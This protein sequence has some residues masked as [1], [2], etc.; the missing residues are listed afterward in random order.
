M[1]P[2]RLTAF[3][4]CTSD[5]KPQ[6]QEAQRIAGKLYLRVSFPNLQKAKDKDTSQ[7]AAREERP[8]RRKDDIWPLLRN[9]ASKKRVE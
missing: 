7:K 2:L 1:E 9:Q 3:P 5:P 8:W 4:K 6:L